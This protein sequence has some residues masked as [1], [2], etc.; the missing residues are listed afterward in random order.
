MKILQLLK[1]LVMRFLQAAYR[2]GCIFVPVSE[3][4]IVFMSFHGRGYGDNPRAIYEEMKKDARFHDH[5]FVWILRNL[6]ETPK[7]ASSVRY[8][9]FSY[10]LAMA[11]ARY[12]IVNCK[13]PQ[14]IYKKQRQIYLQTWHG[15]PLKKLGH[16]IEADEH[17][18][19]YRSGLSLEQMRCS[20]DDDVKKYDFMIS[21][22]RFCTRIFP[23]A[24][25]IPKEKLIES[26]YPR[27]D[28][29]CN[30][31]EE[32]ALEIKKKLGLPLHKKIILYAP[33]WR[34]N[35]YV[36]K[37]Y[38]FELKADFHKWKRELGEEY[39]VLFKPHYSIINS[40]KPEQKEG[41]EEFLYC[42]SPD[43]DISELYIVADLLITDYSSVFFDFAILGRP[44][45]FY[46]YDREEY[47]KEL[48][49]FYLDVDHDLPGEVVTTEEELLKMIKASPYD[50][51]RLK[52]FNQE[53]NSFQDGKSSQKVIESVFFH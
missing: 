38:V 48:R 18:K 28:R 1:K 21:P 13:L 16:D 14:Y 6:E 23:H 34:D 36:A 33:T 43:H 32:E 41:L 50:Y 26:G 4:K 30:A 19:F 24:F 47:D 35:S 15:T 25:H 20:Y 37:G 49:G 8:M 44:M 51:E 12:W 46:M 52:R 2:I 5:T 39:I 22:N 9:S 31:T 17:A 29:L 7:G 11:S 10:F 40:L 3:K 42:I 45:Y 53:F 27:N